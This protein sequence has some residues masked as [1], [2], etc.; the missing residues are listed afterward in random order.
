MPAMADLVIKASDGT[1]DVTMNALAASGS[2]GTPAM[3]RHDTGVNAGVP[4]NARARL[5]VASKWN[6]PK[7]ARQVTFEYVYPYAVQDTTTSLYSTPHQAVLKGIFTLPAGMP[8]AGLKEAAYRGL[9]A[10]SAT[11]IKQAA[12][13]GYAPT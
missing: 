10:I 5:S 6:G 13:T 8:A 3:W 2:D 7:T 12:E 11:L 9:N 1:T 4:S